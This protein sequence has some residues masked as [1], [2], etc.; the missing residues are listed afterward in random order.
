[1]SKP[2]FLSRFFSHSTK[3]KN[4][5]KFR[6]L[7]AKLKYWRRKIKI[8]FEDQ[9]DSPVTCEFYFYEMHIRKISCDESKSELSGHFSITC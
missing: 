2:P 4:F 1:M 7:S 9:K 3:S 5:L 6:R 8:V